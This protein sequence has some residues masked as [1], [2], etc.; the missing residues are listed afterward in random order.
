MA[1][2][3]SL[4]LNKPK[5]LS[6]QL[7]NKVLV[8]NLYDNRFDEAQLALPNRSDER[9]DL[10]EARR[11]NMI[12]SVDVD[13]DAYHLPGNNYGMR[14]RSVI[15]NNN[16]VI[17]E[18]QEPISR[19]VNIRRDVSGAAD[20]NQERRH[21]ILN[22]LTYMKMEKNRSQ[23]ETIP[24]D[25]VLNSNRL[26]FM[27]TEGFLR[28]QSKIVR[29]HEWFVQLQRILRLIMRQQLEWVKDPIV[30]SHDAIAEEVTEYNN[31]RAF[32]IE[33]FE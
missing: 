33:D 9:R 4:V 32:T 5:F 29:W 17:N 26:Q 13:L 19:G 1:G 20:P 11:L 10:N 12:K 8:N 22:T 23:L 3:T 21:N 16:L 30:H 25:G 31:N 2:N 24:I 28:Y 6:D 7:W 18:T 15:Y 14:N 27:G